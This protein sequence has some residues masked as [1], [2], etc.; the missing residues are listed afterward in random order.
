MGKN[1][2]TLFL[3]Y[4]TLFAVLLVCALVM[5]SAFAFSFLSLGI[6]TGGSFTGRCSGLYL[7]GDMEIID[8]LDVIV[9]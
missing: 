6:E 1:L 7:S 4:K 9:L 5:S 3:K 2:T 8:N